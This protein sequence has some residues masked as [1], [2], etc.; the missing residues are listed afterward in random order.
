MN[1]LGAAGAVTNATMQTIGGVGAIAAQQ[2]QLQ[3]QTQ[4]AAAQ[5]VQYKMLAETTLLSGVSAENTA[6]YNADLQESLL[7]SQLAG[8]TANLFQIPGLIAKKNNQ[9]LRAGT[10][11][12]ARRTSSSAASGVSANST[13]DQIRRVQDV[14]YSAFE[15]N[16][17]QAR[18]AAMARIQH[19]FKTY[20][21]TRT[22]IETTK[23]LGRQARMQYRAQSAG[24][25]AETHMYNA[26]ADMYKQQKKAAKKQGVLGI[27][28]NVAKAFLG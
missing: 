21:Q 6:R 28:G 8:E 19:N 12:L 3:H 25:A 4:V 13:M 22:Q 9:V 18:V 23:A 1:F 15:A 27:L 17:A 2:D 26:A 5:A 16:L 20:H 10:A 7:Y 11:E 24:Q 14:E